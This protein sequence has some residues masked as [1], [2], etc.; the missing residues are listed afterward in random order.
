MEE[1][2][3]VGHQNTAEVMDIEFNFVSYDKIPVGILV[4]NNLKTFV[5]NLKIC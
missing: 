4:A 2:P 1:L 3:F 5:I